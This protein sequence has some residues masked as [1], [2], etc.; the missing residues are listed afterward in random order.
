[1]RAPTGE[2]MRSSGRPGRYSSPTATGWSN[3]RNATSRIRSTNCASESI[4]PH[5]TRTYRSGHVSVTALG[6]RGFA[7]GPVRH[8]TSVAPT[9][10]APSVPTRRPPDSREVVHA[11]S[12]AGVRREAD[13]TTPPASCPWR[14]TRPPGADPD[15]RPPVSR[16]AD[17]GRPHRET[18]GPARC[19]QVASDLIDQ[20]TCPGSRRYSV[21]A[22]CG[23]L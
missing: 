9:D 14:S 22:S 8:A 6:R 5:W 23:H 15:P 13:M 12:P 4:T 2:L 11:R 21:I 19:S 3:D 7:V 18:L 1:M 16:N 10:P 20:R 17:G